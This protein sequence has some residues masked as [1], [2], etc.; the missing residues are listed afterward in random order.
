MPKA[1]RNVPAIW[2]PY[3]GDPAPVGM[4]EYLCRN[5]AFLTLHYNMQGNI[6]I[7]LHC[8]TCTP[9]AV[10]MPDNADLRPWEWALLLHDSQ[11]HIVPETEKCLL[12]SIPTKDW[13][14]ECLIG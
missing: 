5:A 6:A 12:L 8:P 4:P 2:A 11:L 3:Y 7:A 1:A 9:H 10:I 14:I 13:Q